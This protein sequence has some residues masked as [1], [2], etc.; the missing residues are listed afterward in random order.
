MGIAEA[1]SG[2]FKRKIRVAVLVSG[3]GSNLGAILKA[4]KSGKIKGAKTV[5]VV[6]DVRDAYALEIARK[7][8]VKAVYIPAA[9]FKTKLEGEP[10]ARYIAALKEAKI[11]LVV[12]AGFM[13]VLKPAFIRAFQGRII[14]VHP[15]LLPKYPGLH[16]H[17]RALEARDTEA[18][19][20]VHFVSE[21]VDGGKRILQ[22][23]VPI[24]PV[25]NADSLARRV[26]DKEHVILPRAIQMFAEGKLD[27]KTFPNEP[28]RG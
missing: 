5:L 14:N 9:N 13:R 3:R 6:S 4:E 15:S 21:V 23:R 18:G 25:D 11:D 24:L 1:F 16:T 7:A 8:G 20:T 10:E 17:A 2:L 28:I 22:A 19:C 12:L 27:E 26:L